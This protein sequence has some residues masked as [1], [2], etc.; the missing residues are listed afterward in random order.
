MAIDFNSDKEHGQGKMKWIV[1]PATEKIERVIHT[2]AGDLQTDNLGRCM[3][4]DP[5]LANE[6][7]QTHRKDLAVSRIFTNDPADREHKYFFGQLPALPWHRY[8]E[9]GN[10]IKEQDN[11]S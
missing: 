4:S 9:N 1:Q 7:R 6:I 10:R 8:D 5:V 3:I 11:G 2:G